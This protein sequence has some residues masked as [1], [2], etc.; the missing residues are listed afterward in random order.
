MDGCFRLDLVNVIFL[1]CAKQP[2]IQPRTRVHFLATLAV[3]LYVLPPVIGAVEVACCRKYQFHRVHQSLGL[4]SDDCFIEGIQAW[5]LSF[6]KFP[7]S[8]PASFVLVAK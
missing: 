7:K 1:P 5:M 4:I 3:F 8:V 2:I 6:C